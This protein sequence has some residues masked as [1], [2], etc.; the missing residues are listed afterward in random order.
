MQPY[1]QLLTVLSLDKGVQVRVWLVNPNSLPAQKVREERRRRT[2]IIFNYQVGKR[3]TKKII[4]RIINN[5]CFVRLN[6]NH[7]K[8]EDIIIYS[9]VLFKLYSLNSNTCT[10]SN[11][12][13]RFDSIRYFINTRSTRNGN[14]MERRSIVWV[15]IRVMSSLVDLL[16]V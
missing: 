16:C 9:C 12:T 4:K 6:T 7:N 3:R 2:G 1:Y 11:S 13:V 10:G 8:Y 14:G 5:N 15:M